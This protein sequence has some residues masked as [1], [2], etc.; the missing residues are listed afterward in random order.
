MN[1]DE[2]A[3]PV[4]MIM[5]DGIVIRGL[6]CPPQIPAG[7]LRIPEDSQDSILADVQA[8]FWSPVGVYS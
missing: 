2:N 3:A 1:I 6:Y 8:N 4:K 7:F 5:M